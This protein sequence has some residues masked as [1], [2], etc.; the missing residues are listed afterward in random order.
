[1]YLEHY[2]L[3]RKP[4]Q[5]DTDPAFLWLGEKQKEALAALKYGLHESTGCLVLTGDAG[6]G[7]TTIIKALPRFLSEND[8]V[9]VISD[10]SLGKMD[11]FNH[12]A[13][14]FRMP[15]E[16]ASKGAFIRDFRRL[17]LA[18]HYRGRRVLLIID[19]AQLLKSDLL[20][21]LRLISNLEKNG[22]KLLRIFFI[23]QKE[24]NETLLRPENKAI[25]QRIT[26]NYNIDPLTEK[27]V[28][29]YV[30]FR[31][32]VAGGGQR[33]FTGDA[34]SGIFHFSKGNPRLVNVIADRALLTGFVQS[35]RRIKKK[36]IEECARDLDISRSIP[37]IP[38]ENIKSDS[39]KAE[40][41]TPGKGF[42]RAWVLYPVLAALVVIILYLMSGPILEILPVSLF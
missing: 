34:V 42:R 38:A 39:G 41:K 36:V 6:A 5:I 37:S 16:Y 27:E 31:L 22:A 32:A 2:Q 21:E 9:V 4:F 33:I 13:S 14:A 24:L 29:E 35:E 26:V 3:E 30:K 20:E 40:R 8:R 25:R 10:P 19:E 7:K 11:F 28:G 15:V 1:M 12:M 23:G 18:H 17:L